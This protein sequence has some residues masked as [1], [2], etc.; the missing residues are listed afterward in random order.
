MTQ[1]I[2]PKTPR[3]MYGFNY[4]QQYFKNLK[5]FIEGQKNKSASILYRKK[6]LEHR[7]KVKYTNEIQRIRGEISR[8][9]PR[10]PDG[11]IERLKARIEH[12][13]ELGGQIV[14]KIK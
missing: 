12:L 4:S 3:D 5:D 10:L 6:L 13:K 7:D 2:Y 14:D 1:K 11:T 9:N 8:N